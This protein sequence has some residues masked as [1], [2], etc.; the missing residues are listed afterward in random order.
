[1]K[2]SIDE[3]K[4]LA[5]KYRIETLKM[6]HAAKSGHPGGSLSAVEILTTL[7]Y[8]VIHV[9]EDPLD[10]RRDR[11]FFSKGHC[12][13][14]YYAILADLGILEQDELMTL[15]KFGSRLQGHPNKNEIPFVD[16]N[17]GS[18]GQGVSAGTGMALGF[19]HQGKDNHVYVLIGDGECDEGIVWEAASAAC[20]YKLD[21]LTWIV[22]MNTVQLDGA[23]KDIMNLGDVPA[24]F[25]AIGFVVDEVNGHDF[26]ELYAAFQKKESGKPHVIIAHTTKGKGVSFMENNADW[27]GKAPNDEQLAQALQELEEQ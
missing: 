12:N 15:R 25:Q 20:H 2:H 1:M 22:D 21:N 8:E 10:E 6:I 3:L 18:L 4:Q 16:F 19:K 17:A 26:E 24:R 9:Y 11:F 7:F 27:H 13:P 5:K 14:P 23:T